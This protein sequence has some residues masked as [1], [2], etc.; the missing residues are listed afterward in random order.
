MYIYGIWILGINHNKLA[1]NNLISY[2]KY[3][4]IKYKS[5][6]LVAFFLVCFKKAKS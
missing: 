5:L 6:Y 2:K 1:E 4:S 3:I